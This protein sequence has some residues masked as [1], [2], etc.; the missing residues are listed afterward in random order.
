MLAT[1]PACKL[2]VTDDQLLCPCGEDLAECRAF[3]AKYQ[4]PSALWHGDT[5]VLDIAAFRK[6]TPASRREI[7]HAINRALATTLKH[8]Q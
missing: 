2:P 1:C 6:L 7:M 4:R 8:G 3:V 5:P